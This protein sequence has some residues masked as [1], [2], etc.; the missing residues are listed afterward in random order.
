MD[1]NAIDN[2]QKEL[3][4][5]EQIKQFKDVYGFN[6]EEY[7][8]GIR[9]QLQT[10]YIQQESFSTNSTK[11]FS[12]SQI[13]IKKT[14]NVDIVDT[15]TKIYLIK[16]QDSIDLVMKI[17]FEDI[18][19]VSEG[20]QCDLFE[21][22]C[23]LC[24]HEYMHLLSGHLDLDTLKRA[25]SFA[26][27]NK[28]R[29]ASNSWSS[30]SLFIPDSYIDFCLYDPD[31]GMKNLFE[32]PIMFNIACDM[33][34][35]N[36][37]NMKSPSLRASDFGLPEGLNEF[38][39]Y[40]IIYHLL[41]SYPAGTVKGEKF[42]ST[43][44]QNYIAIHYM[45]AR[46]KILQL[47][48]SC[49]EQAGGSFELNDQYINT[50]KNDKNI[51]FSNDIDQ[52]GQNLSN[53]CFKNLE[54]KCYEEIQKQ[55]YD[56]LRG[57]IHEYATKMKTAQTGIWSD[58]N[59]VLKELERKSQ[60]QKMSYIDRVDDWCKFNTR[61]D[62]YGLL[63]PGKNKISGTI[64]RKIGDS[65]VIFIDISG[66]MGNVL[67]PLFTFCY[68]A[69]KKCNCTIVFYDTQIITEC[70]KADLLKLEPMI[71]GGTCVYNALK[72]YEKKHKTNCKAI[73]ILSDCEDDYTQVLKE[74]NDVSIWKID[75]NKIKKYNGNGEFIYK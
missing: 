71:A 29:I 50:T 28:N 51:Q 44:R 24:T 33:Y 49:I 61:K 54:N 8:K 25:H 21:A 60:K 69:L 30:R 64:E 47:W 23:K 38:H 72:E 46:E 57:N 63:Y 34:I 74:Y 27:L 40:G 75:D 56:N 26:T 32:N 3:S 1:N 22:F 53:D 65:Y 70:T 55:K 42:I 37:I 68:Y 13:K 43:G 45:P 6:I 15:G 39:Y 66:S 17:G 67:E 7:V 73:T 12:K 36:I 59:K 62:G 35:N 10:L 16:F 4:L 48:L 41:N 2:P 11:I 20:N 9:K 5:K 19:M 14:A 31:L 58:F 18:L 52:N